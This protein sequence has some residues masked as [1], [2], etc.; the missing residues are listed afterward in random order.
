MAVNEKYSGWIILL[1]FINHTI[2]KDIF[3]YSSEALGWQYLSRSNQKEALFFLSLFT[4][5]YAVIEWCKH[6]NGH[7]LK[8]FGCTY[9]EI[10]NIYN[11]ID[12]AISNNQ[13]REIQ[14]M[15]R[16]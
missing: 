13:W 1:Y 3:F 2:Y 15:P 5:K 16:Q 8:I 14:H 12:K 9:A 7:L 6:V 11:N 4:I 10:M